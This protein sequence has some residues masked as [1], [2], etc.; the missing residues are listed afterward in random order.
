M[1]LNVGGGFNSP[2]QVARAAA[3]PNDDAAPA[4]PATATPAATAL[5]GDTL[6]LQTVPLTPAQPKTAA[7]KG[8]ADEALFSAYWEKRSITVFMAR[9]KELWAEDKK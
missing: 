1:A 5:V 9:M 6:D 2:L 7:G 3:L 4:A 8:Q